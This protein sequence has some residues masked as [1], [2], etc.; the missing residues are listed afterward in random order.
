MPPSRTV[1][2]TLQSTGACDDA[3]CPYIHDL[4]FCDICGM[5]WAIEQIYKAHLVSRLHQRKVSGAGGN[6]YCPVC[7]MRIS[8]SKNW[9]QHL[10]GRRH[11]RNASKQGIDPA[12]V[13]PEVPPQPKNDIHCHVCNFD[14]RAHQWNAHV[15]QAKHKSREAFVSLK[16]VLDDAAK[17]RNGVTVSHGEVGIDFGVVEVAEAA[18][19]VR[20]SVAL[21]IT[22]P[23]T[24]IRLVE[25][26]LASPSTAYG[27]YVLCFPAFSSGFSRSDSFS[28]SRVGALGVTLKY[29][30]GTTLLEVVLKQTL[31][32][33]F[34]DR[35]Q[36]TFEDTV[37]Q[38]HF[39]IIR[40][41]KAVIGN[42]SEYELLKPRTPYV[43]RPRAA[44]EPEETVI[45]GPPPPALSVVKWVVKLPQAPIP[46]N[47]ATLLASGTAGEVVEQ[48]RRTVLPKVLNT[49]TYG[50]H[51]KNVIWAEEHRME[52][53]LQM[54]DII[55]AV[56][57]PHGRYYY[58]NVPGL[59]EKRP[60]V[61]TG[62][63]ILVRPQHTE[64]G[65]WYEG[66]VHVV[67]QMEVGLC[68]H[69]SFP[70]PAQNTRHHIHFKLQRIPL[71]RQHQA[72]DTAFAADR[73]LFP[74][75]AHIKTRSPAKS[76]TIRLFNPLIASNRPQIEA[77]HA[78]MSLPPGSM[79]FIL[80]G[81]RVPP[82]CTGKTITVVEAV[83][84]LIYH[85]RSTRVLA[86]A[87]SNSAA[88]L[89]A[90]RLKDLGN[91]VVFRF[92]APSRAKE[93]VPTELLSFTYVNDSGHFG[94]PPVAVLKRFRIII[95]TC[96]SASFGHNVGVPRGHFTHI[97]VDEAGQATE[98]EV[99]ISVKTMADLQTNVV[100]A[101]DPRQ[102][103]PIIRSAVA[104]RLGL[105]ISYMERLM[106]DPMY[107]EHQGH[108]VTVVKLTKNY[109]SH[110][111]I[112]KFPNEKFYGGELVPCA[113]IRIMEACLGSSVL[114][115]KKFPVVFHA[116]C[117][118]DDR[119]SSSPSFF[120][121]LEV[122]EVKAY[123]EK[124][125]SDRTLKIS[126]RD[127]GVIAPYHA[128]CQKIRKIL[129][130][131]NAEEVKVGSVEEFQGQ[132]RRVIIISTVRSSRDFVEYDLKHT[133]GFVANPRRFNVAVT[134]AQSLLI[135][136][137]DPAVLS[138]DPLW[139]SF[140]N[141]V[142]IRGGW[143]GIPIPWDPREAVREEGGYDAEAR[144]RGTAD[145]N[146]LADMIQSMALNG[147]CEQID[148]TDVNVDRPWRE[149]E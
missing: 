62:D 5:S 58:L 142:S 69:G 17:D 76:F 23:N 80:F 134:R 13:E 94:L 141:Y 100:L 86:C 88:D 11:C 133:L 125:R 70:V 85:S 110:E 14:V 50:R 117:G 48:L 139:R 31:R 7:D 149:V 132:E 128:Q 57:V 27:R 121:I 65:K 122:Q 10:C 43:P 140:L 63:R 32:G 56:L 77:V 131:V 98:P 147:A 55:D 42:P 18:A 34:N 116:I 124:L 89:L 22:D 74:T 29:G 90:S 148:E 6:F 79:P 78:I 28:V 115:S 112:I 145:M 102:L 106:K 71:R 101:G 54:Y 144:L 49:E 111:A 33:H 75:S 53:D 97:F 127:I 26:R 52:H 137:G 104:R 8:G 12:H 24:K 123:I 2:A 46:P 47:L 60:S 84:Q 20:T 87:P 66:H 108:G 39:I 41:I 51:W 1:C 135:I 64:R 67:H 95:C 96:V 103:G 118:K 15:K 36:I 130:S 73:L 120:N 126:T 113:D 44:R 109:R 146:A 59:A 35:L 21:K 91:D 83:R 4:F 93:A 99:M 105:D 19:S 9:T 119:E 37:L 114:V 16:A 143:T 72:L 129:R 136:I 38:Q 81:P 25:A 3:S 92:Y 45:L 138:L 40:K 82:Y 107:D 61:L 30:D 68:F